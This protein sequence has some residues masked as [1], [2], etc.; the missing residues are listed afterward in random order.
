MSDLAEPVAR[1]AAL[2]P[3]RDLTCDLSDTLGHTGALGRAFQSVWPGATFAGPAL[4][5]RTV[6]T[7]L[8]AVYAGIA[9]APAGSVVVI[10][11]HGTDHSAFWGENTTR[12]AQARGVVAA[13]I[14]GACRDVSAVRALRFPV[15]CTGRIPQAGLRGPHG[16]VNVP[17]ALGGVPVHPGDLIVGDDNGVVV[18]PAAEAA[19]VVTAVLDAVGAAAID[20]HSGAPF[21]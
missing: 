17:V 2:L 21:R 14:D 10:D 19:R 7:D 8:G 11:T 18:L 15:V 13:V 5:V 3:G 6:G 16:E 12:A 1:L 4:T 9:A 20:S